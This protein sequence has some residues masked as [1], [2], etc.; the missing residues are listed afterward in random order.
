MNPLR[1]VAGVLIVALFAAP[2]RATTYYIDAVSGSNRNAGTSPT[3]AW[4]TPPGSSCECPASGPCP[5]RQ[6]LVTSEGGW[7]AF[8]KFQGGDSI[9]FNAGQSHSFLWNIQSNFFDAQPSGRI[10]IGRYGT[11]AD[12]IIEGGGDPANLAE[13]YAPVF[14]SLGNNRWSFALDCGRMANTSLDHP[15]VYRAGVR[16]AV[17]GTIDDPS[18]AGGSCNSLDGPFQMFH[19]CSGNRVCVFST[20]DPNADPPGT[21]YVGWRRLGFNVAGMGGLTFQN[22][23]FRRKGSIQSVFGGEIE[24]QAGTTDPHIDHCTFDHSGGVGVRAF[25]SGTAT[26]CLPSELVVGLELTNSVVH[27]SWAYGV[28]IQ[29]CDNTMFTHFVLR[30]NTIY[31]NGD[32]GISAGGTRGGLLENNTS[33]FNGAGNTQCGDPLLP[34]APDA[35]RTASGI[36]GSGSRADPTAFTKDVT[37]NANTSYYNGLGCRLQ[38]TRCSTDCN[39]ACSGIY[40]DSITGTSNVVSNNFVHDNW[41]SFVGL[42]NIKTGVGISILN[43]SALNNHTAGIFDYVGGIGDG[44]FTMSDNILEYDLTTSPQ[45]YNVF[46]KSSFNQ[47]FQANDNFSSTFSSREYFCNGTVQQTSCFPN[48]SSNLSVDPQFDVEEATV[49]MQN[50]GQTDLH[51]ASTSPLRGKGVSTAPTVTTDFD[52][53]PRTGS[54]DIGGDQFVSGSPT[55]TTPAPATTSTTR[56]PTTTTSSTTVTTTSSST[57]STIR[58]AT[59]STSTSSTTSTSGPTTTSTSTTLPAGI[60][61]GDPGPP[62]D[63]TATMTAGAQ[64]ESGFAL[65]SAQTVTELR[66]YLQGRSSAQ[67]VRAVIYSDAGGN[68]DALLATSV[69]VVVAPNQAP[70]FVTF[71]LPTPLQLAAGTYHLGLW[72]G[73][74]S[75]AA[76]GTEATGTRV[77]QNVAYSSTGDPANPWTGTSSLTGSVVMNAVCASVATTTSTSSSTSTTSS[78]T[79]STSRTTSSTTSSSTTTSSS[80]TTSSTRPT[81][82]TSTSSTSTTSSTVPS[83]VCFGDAGPPADVSATMTANARRESGFVLGS[84]QTVTA[85]RAYLLGKSG[86]QPVRAVIYSD[87][88][89]SAGA[90]LAASVEVVVA[91]NQAPGFVTFALPAPLPLAAGTY[92]LGLWSGGTTAAGMGTQTTG[93]RVSENDT[94]SSTGNPGSPWAGTSSLTGSLVMNAACG[95]AAQTTTTTSSSTSSTTGVPPSTISPT[96]TTTPP[97]TTTLPSSADLLAGT[98]LVLFARAGDPSSNTLDLSAR[99]SQITIGA[100]NSSLDD[101]TVFGGS[102]R[103]VSAAAGFDR[104]YPLPAQNWSLVGNPGANAGYKYR[105]T[106]LVAGPIKTVDLKTASSLDTSGLGAGLAFDLPTSPDPVGVVLFIGAHRECLSFGGTTTFNGSRYNATDSPAP[107][108]C[109]P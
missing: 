29:N 109:A 99:G 9:L 11:G 39:A 52:G 57:T 43:N 98:K 5:V 2:V 44:Q 100:G 15:Q 59:T 66:A 1:A 86:P 53:Q 37:I 6:C 10:T 63:L 80:S 42:N 78:S 84:A 88:G 34:C 91:A 18:K 67:P 82:S 79:T 4:H 69:E 25:P 40:I 41:G 58:P 7:P 77:S 36:V 75:P 49:T 94:Y 105:D 90:L 31:Q 87:A 45:W 83:G 106:N 50:V 27:D 51:I 26:P 70:G 61:F 101:P 54:Y 14:K 65:G 46:W 32:H 8:G 103:I 64:R 96:T 12:P 97:T 68:A 13:A 102:L 89:G 108:S 74:S 16:F 72:S 35:Q 30:G 22:L 76:M 62:A 107:L 85:L 48:G 73:G 23:T 71:R 3:A 21:W 20:T 33:Y 19:E 95:G 104:T 28:E 60:C 38:P 92:H 81:T 47:T 93:T 55:T 56:P 24:I 17:Q